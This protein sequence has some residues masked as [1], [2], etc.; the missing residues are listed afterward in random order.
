MRIC[1]AVCRDCDARRTT[2]S[3]GFRRRALSRSVPGMAAR[4]NLL[5]PSKPLQLNV[6]LSP[7]LA[8]A[9]AQRAKDA[10]LPQRIVV[11][12]ALQAAGLAVEPADLID[13]APPR[14]AR[15]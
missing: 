12:R 1:G 2:R 14:V 13:S 8:Q 3:K 11:A 7:T 10:G 15:A 5:P 6:R 4:T 9:V